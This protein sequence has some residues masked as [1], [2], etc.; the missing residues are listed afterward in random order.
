MKCQLPSLVAFVEYLNSAFL[1]MYVRKHVAWIRYMSTPSEGAVTECII[2]SSKLIPSENT[3]T[4]L[5]TIDELRLP[6]ESH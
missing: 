4:G 3:E 2:R 1:S 6:P 5:E